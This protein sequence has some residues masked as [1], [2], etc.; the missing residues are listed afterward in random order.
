MNAQYTRD[1]PSPRYKELVQLYRQ[2]HEEGEQFLGIP[3]GQTFPGQSL[4]PQA[5]RIKRLIDM[6]HSRTL[7]DYGSGKG[8]QYKMSPVRIPNIGEFKSM[9]EYFGVESIY[10]YDPSYM[11]FSRLPKDFFD[12]VISTD[13]LEHC[14]EPDLSWIIDE[15]FSYADKFVF[16]SVCCAPANKRL[17]N[18]ENAHCTIRPPEWWSQLFSKVAASHPDIRWEIVIIEKKNGAFIESSLASD[19]T[20]S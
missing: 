4:P 17:A 13:V 5:G 12:G 6:T 2:M 7:L 19:S 8:L 18:G 14:P 20:Q 16:T 9:Q 1:N 11:P 3:P 10:C 15:I